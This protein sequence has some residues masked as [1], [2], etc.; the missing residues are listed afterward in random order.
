MRE[1]TR[2]LTRGAALGTFAALATGCGLAKSAV[3][4]ITGQCIDGPYSYPLHDSGPIIR[5]TVPA[6]HV[7][8]PVRY[9]LVLPRSVDPHTVDRVVY[10]LPGRGSTA[11]DAVT[12]TGYA[13]LAQEI[14]RAGGKPFAV[15]AIDSGESYFHPRTSGEDRLRIVERDLPDVARSNLAPHI[16][17]EALV[18]VSMGGY[19]ALLT[20]E[21]N[22]ARYKAVAVAGPALF[23]SFAEENQAIGDGFDNAAQFATYDVFA[24]A[25]RLAHVPVMIRVGYAD[26]FYSNVKVFA[27]RV[28]HADVRYVEHGCH[29]DGFWRLAGHDLLAFASS[30]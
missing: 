30:H 17:Y 15:L 1:L 22:P 11:D 6:S 2:T 26:P 19:G 16:Q 23:Q 12:F 29:D 13:A 18:G 9:A 8:R 25:D 7:Q 20:A 24:H 4:H 21:R 28:P 10:V 14:M 27:K 3:R 5:G